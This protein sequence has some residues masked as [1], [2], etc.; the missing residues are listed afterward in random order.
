MADDPAKVS[1]MT[2][3]A[4][5]KL[6]GCGARAAQ[7]AGDERQRTAIFGV[8]IGSYGRPVNLAILESSGL[9][10]LDKLVLQC[11]LRAN[12]IP[13]APDRQPIQWLFETL[14]QPKHAE[15]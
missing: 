5:S 4:K 14:L 12:Y 7:S 8:Y 2:P 13:T 3:A 9:E 1:V 6:E 10:N 15:P 11:L